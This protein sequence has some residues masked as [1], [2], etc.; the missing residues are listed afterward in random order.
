M[1]LLKLNTTIDRWTALLDTVKLGDKERFDKE[2]IGVKE[3]FPI[4]RIVNLLHK[5]KEHL[6]LRNNFRVTKKFLI[7]KFDC[8]YLSISLS[9]YP[10]HRLQST[11]T[12]EPTK[13]T[14]FHTRKKKKMY[15]FDKV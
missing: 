4:L 8:M 11:Q 14:E 13:V 3:P 12:L 2:Q 7:T 15:L 5:D 1:P 10:Y 9:F 6:A